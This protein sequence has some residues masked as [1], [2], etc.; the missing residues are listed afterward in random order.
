MKLRSSNLANVSSMAGFTPGVNN[1]PT[2]EAW[3]E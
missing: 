2:K 3:S 1:F